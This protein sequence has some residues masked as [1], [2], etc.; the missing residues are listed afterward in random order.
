MPPNNIISLKNLKKKNKLKLKKQQI[1][2]MKEK[3]MKKMKI[4]YKMNQKNLKLIYEL[5][6]NNIFININNYFIFFIQ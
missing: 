6:K 3:I 2:Q 4:F 1:F 5:I